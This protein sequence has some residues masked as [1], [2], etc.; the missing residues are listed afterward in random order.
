MENRFDKLDRA[1]VGLGT[2]S[3]IWGLL[4]KD[5]DHRASH[6]LLIDTRIL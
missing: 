3:A 1:E 6:E 4:D 5:D 2:S